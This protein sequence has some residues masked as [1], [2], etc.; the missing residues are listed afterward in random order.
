[1]STYQQL[2][3]S[4]TELEVEFRKK[5]N[6]LCKL[7]VDDLTAYFSERMVKHHRTPFEVYN[8]FVQILE[9]AKVQKSFGT[10]SYGGLGGEENNIAGRVKRYK[11]NGY[12]RIELTFYGS[13]LRNIKL[14]WRRRVCS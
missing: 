13:S 5:A 9:S 3:F 6:R 8:K 12:T 2:G 10:H 7:Q 11:K 4:H 1:M 14:R